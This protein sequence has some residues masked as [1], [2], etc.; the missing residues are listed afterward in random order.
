MCGAGQR[1]VR[2][3]H[4]LVPI[5]NAPQDCIYPASTKAAPI[6]VARRTHDDRHCGQPFTSFGSLR[7]FAKFGQIKSGAQ[8]ARYVAFD[9]DHQQGGGV[10]DIECLVVLHEVQF[11]T[12]ANPCKYAA[13]PTRPARAISRRVGQMKRDCFSTIS[14]PTMQVFPERPFQDTFTSSRT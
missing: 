7:D 10:V 6:V 9:A 5:S 12:L 14:Q 13:S 2:C 3:F 1:G 8:S 11:L 4:A